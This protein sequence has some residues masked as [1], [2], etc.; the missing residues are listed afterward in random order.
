MIHD[1]YYCLTKFVFLTCISRFVVC[2]GGTITWLN[3]SNNS[4]QPYNT[5][6]SNEEL[7]WAYIIVKLQQKYG[8]RCVC[9]PLHFMCPGVQ[10]PLF[11]RVKTTEN[12]SRLS[13]FI[14]TNQKVAQNRW[15]SSRPHGQ[16][17]EE[18][19]NFHTLVRNGKI[20]EPHC[21]SQTETE[22]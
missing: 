17:S 16:C 1:R 14:L 13:F 11:W 5:P 21:L 6:H 18:S 15:T 2:K 10:A 20:N 12:R 19:L 22:R 4:T 7:R 3:P 8:Y 9:F